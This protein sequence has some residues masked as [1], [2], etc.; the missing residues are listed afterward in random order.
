MS[1]KRYDAVCIGACLMDISTSTLDFD[2]FL[3]TEPNLVD[4]I[5]Y[6]VGGDA[7]NE[8]TVLSKL[9]FRSCFLGRVG[10]DFVGKFIIETAEKEGVD[11]SRVKIAPGAPTAAN[12]ILIGKNDKRVYIISRNPT[13]RTE[14]CGDDIDLD[15]V[16]NAKLVSIGS[17]FIHPKLDGALESILRE[18]KSS[19]SITCADVCPSGVECSLEPLRG[20]MGQLD[21]F[22]ANESEAR[23]LSG[24]TTPDDMADYFLGLG[25]GT[26]IIKLGV[27]GS[28][29]KNSAGGFKA[30]AYPVEAVDTTGAGDCYAGGFMSGLIRGLPLTECAKIA[31]ATSALT[32]GC[33]GATAGIK[34]MEQVSEFLKERDVK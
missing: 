6:T 11:A 31:S 27:K 9:G 3:E 19:G 29:I 7:F 18:A 5:K 2:T 30:Q 12:N 21:Y 32:V 34:G 20:A 25:A 24:K 15:A 28:Y 23:Y 10:A 16:R 1:E 26:V 8:A 4:G 22:F 33:V 14:L 17:I 13:S